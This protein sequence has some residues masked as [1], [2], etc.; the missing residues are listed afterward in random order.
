MIFTK[1]RKQIWAENYLYSILKHHTHIVV[2]ITASYPH[3]S[4][5]NDFL[6]FYIRTIWR[7]KFLVVE[8]KCP[9]SR[10]IAI[11]LAHNILHGIFDWIKTN[12][13]SKFKSP[14]ISFGDQKESSHSSNS[15][16]LIFFPSDVSLL[17]QFLRYLQERLGYIRSL[18]PSA[19]VG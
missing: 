8:F 4:F 17:N 16:F 6:N 10:V 5:L 9:V 11:R 7:F 13:F 3:Y 14:P 18:Y 12:I 1:K 2:K 15:L 19:I